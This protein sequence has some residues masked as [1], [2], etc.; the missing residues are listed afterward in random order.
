M[1]MKQF[2]KLFSALAVILLVSA[3]STTETPEIKRYNTPRFTDK[4]PIE[5]K[6]NKVETVS[7][8][9]PQFKA[10]YVEHMFPIPLEATAKT[11]AKDRLSAVDYSSDKTATFIIKDASVTEEIEKSE[12]VFYKDR[13]KYRATLYVVI[14]VT[15]P[16]NL[17]SAETS[18]EAW[19]E[20]A[21]PADT[22]IE[23]KERYWNGMVYKLFDE[24]N[25]RMEQ[26]IYQYLNMYVANNSII[27]EYN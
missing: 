26:N 16:K 19:R 21:I 7:E 9:T 12:K 24:F 14:K 13:I 3:C 20:L 27:Q 22:D 17:S 1:T 5:L 6:V 2:K 8:F 15:D 10:P 4:A 23:E 25:K 18:I 11:W